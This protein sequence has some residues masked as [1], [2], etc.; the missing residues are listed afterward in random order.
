LDLYTLGFDIGSSSV[1]VALLNLETGKNDA[2]AFSPKNEMPITALRAGWAEQD[3]NMWWE[4]LKLATSEILSA[5]HI[6]HDQITTKY[7]D[8]YQ[9]WSSTLHR[10]LQSKG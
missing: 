8:L 2:N 1:K 7:Q 6:K 10:I 4:N 5:A 9:Q 3:P